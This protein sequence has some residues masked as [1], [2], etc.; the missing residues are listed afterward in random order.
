[1][2]LIFALLLSF[3]T[4]FAADSEVIASGECGKEG[5]NITWSLDS[6]GILILSGNGDMADYGNESAVP[7]K[8]YKEQIKNVEFRGNITSVG[9]NTFS[10]C[11]SLALTKLPEEI[12]VIGNRAFSGCT[13]LTLTELPEGLISIG[14]G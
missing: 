13:L 11:T 12:T 10:G 3:T 1:M 14:Y 4:A 5:N 8:N 9:Y 7:W 2:L 6:D